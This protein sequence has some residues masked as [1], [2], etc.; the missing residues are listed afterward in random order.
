L[1]KYITWIINNKEWLFSGAG[2]AILIWI[3]R[4]I[5]KKNKALFSQKIRAGA[6]SA[7]VQAGRDINIA[8]KKKNDVE[9]D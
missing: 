4:L 8:I 2:L 1:D 5:I 9:K 3:Y 7:N 6:S